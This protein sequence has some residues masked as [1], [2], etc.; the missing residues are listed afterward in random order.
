MAGENFE[1]D[2]IYS[3]AA[4]LGRAPASAI[5]LA[6][7]VV[8]KSTADLVRIGKRNAPVDTGNLRNSISGSTTDLEGEAGPTAAYGGFVERGTSRM[9]PQPYMAP[10]LDAVAPGFAQAIA[11]LGEEAIDG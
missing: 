2:E 6:R 8:R 10:A 7:L 11:Q 9:A 3:L 4:D 1:M 5:P